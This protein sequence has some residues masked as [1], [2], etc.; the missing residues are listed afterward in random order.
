MIPSSS[1]NLKLLNENQLKSAKRKTESTLDIT[2]KERDSPEAIINFINKK[3]IF[4]SIFDEE[5]S[6]KFLSSKD[7][8]LRDVILDD[9]IE[10]DENE[11]YNSISFMRKF[12]FNKEKYLIKDE[13]NLWI[14]NPFCYLLNRNIYKSY[15][16]YDK[17]YNLNEIE[18]NKEKEIEN[19][20]KY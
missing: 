15:K 3:I 20:F 13:E 10:E 9:E 1:K 16:L 12:T 14:K 8:A 2:N 19:N 7:L 18:Q 17:Y 6:D 4:E 5:G 11:S